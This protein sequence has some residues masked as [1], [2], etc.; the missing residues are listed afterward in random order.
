[1]CRGGTIDI[2]RAAELLRRDASDVAQVLG[3]VI[4]DD[5]A[6][7]QDLRDLLGDDFDEFIASTATGDEDTSA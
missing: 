6:I 7:D 5:E 2:A 4:D 1:M 3:A